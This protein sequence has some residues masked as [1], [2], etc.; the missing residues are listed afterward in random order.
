MKQI[1]VLIPPLNQGLFLSTQAHRVDDQEFHQLAFVVEAAHMRLSQ[2]LLRING[3]TNLSKAHPHTLDFDLRVPL[4][5]SDY[6]SRQQLQRV[7]GKNPREVNILAEPFRF[8]LGSQ[9]RQKEVR[10][11]GL[12]QLHSVKPAGCPADQQRSP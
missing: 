8:G 3:E 5:I 12:L 6:E 9:R 4:G 7:S 2:R 1:L 10:V 11:I